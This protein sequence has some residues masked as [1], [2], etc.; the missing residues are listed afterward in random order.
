MYEEYWGLKEKPFR[1]TPNPKYLYIS[2]DHEEALTR[3]LYAVAER[4]GGLLLTGDYGCGKTLLSRV[5]LRELSPV[6]YE[7]AIVASPNLSPTEFLQEV[8]YQFGVSFRAGARKVGSP[9]GPD[10]PATKRELRHRLEAFLDACERTGR[11]PVLL[12]D[13][14]QMV[15]DAETLEEMRLLL[16]YQHDDRFLLTLLLAGQPELR[17]IIDRVPQFKQ[18]LTLRYHLGPLSQTGVPLYVRHR[19]ARAGASAEVFTP[20]AERAIHAATRGVPREIN[21]LG[22]L[23]LL[24][25]C[26]RSAREI[27]PEL[28]WE[29]A[30]DLA[31]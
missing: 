4:K 1:N 14:A 5:L 18:R 23:A 30:R 20:D 24:V 2:E 31:A 11:H 16:N 9:E 28:V 7:M 3:L 13:E 6:R 10:G 15:S 21:S 19:M 17:G 8:L 12:V 27:G 22:D 29:V 25:G 26:G